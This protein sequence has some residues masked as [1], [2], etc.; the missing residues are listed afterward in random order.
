MT[1]TASGDWTEPGAHEVAPGVHRL[2]LP[3]PNDGLRAVNVYVVATEDGLVCV[4]GGWAIPA[5]RELLA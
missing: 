4:D 1:S 5:S 2:P 3:L